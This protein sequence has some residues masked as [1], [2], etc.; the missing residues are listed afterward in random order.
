MDLQPYLDAISELIKVLS[1]LPGEYWDEALLVVV[2]V[3]TLKKVGL[4]EPYEA[5]ATI[6][7]SYLFA[8]DSADVALATPVIAVG[9]SLFHKAWEVIYTWLKSLQK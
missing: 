4:V 7:L 2:L 9:G 5:F 1:E 6:G 3:G 8:K